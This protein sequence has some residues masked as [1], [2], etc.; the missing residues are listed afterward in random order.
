MRKYKKIYAFRLETKEELWL[1][2]RVKQSRLSPSTVMRD[3]IR[4]KI[5]L[6]AAFTPRPTAPEAF[7]PLA[8]KTVHDWFKDNAP[9]KEV[10]TQ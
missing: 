5:S 4:E 10:P 8:G 6:E 3:L 1:D 2:N 9:K 7:N